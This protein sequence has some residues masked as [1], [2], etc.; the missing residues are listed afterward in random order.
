[1]ITLNVTQIQII[2]GG[3]GCDQ[4]ILT[5]TLPD[6][7]YPYTGNASANIYVAKGKGEE[8]LKEHFPSIVPEITRMG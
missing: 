4:V 3:S 8:W 1:M 7:C 2:T 6:G 5:T